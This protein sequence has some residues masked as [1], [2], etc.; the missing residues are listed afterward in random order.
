MTTEYNGITSHPI[1]SA[2]V[3]VF[4]MFFMIVNLFLW[5]TY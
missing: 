4:I 5:L 3:V 2:F 1:Q